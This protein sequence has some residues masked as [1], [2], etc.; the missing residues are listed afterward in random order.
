[1]INFGGGFGFR[2]SRGEETVVDLLRGQAREGSAGED[3]IDRRRRGGADEGILERTVVFLLE[4]RVVERAVFD[5]RTTL[6]RADAI[7]V[8]LGRGALGFKWIARVE[9]AVLQEQERIA[10]DLVGGGAGDYIDGPAR[11]SAR[12]GR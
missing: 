9:C 4:R 2:P 12:L 3:A 5:D 7:T 1:M 6:R 10:V 8:Q 11:R